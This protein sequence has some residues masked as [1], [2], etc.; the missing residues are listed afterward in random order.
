VKV[1]L[2]G[3]VEN[4]SYL[5]APGSGERIDVFG[6]GGGK[7]TAEA[8]GI[9][10]LGEL[11]LNPRIRVGGD[12][13]RPIALLGDSDPESQPFMDMARQILKATEDGAKPKGP[14]ISI[15]D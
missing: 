7:R 15:E 9:P 3:M 4:M 11:P 5:V 13:G 8:M 2:L 6:E 1:P 10:F 14:S 12:S